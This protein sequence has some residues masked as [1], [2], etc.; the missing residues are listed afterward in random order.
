MQFNYGTIVAEAMNM[1][2]SLQFITKLDSH[3]SFAMNNFTYSTVKIYVPRQHTI[4]NRDI[5]HLKDIFV[6]VLRHFKDVHVRFWT[7][8]CLDC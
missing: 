6:T 8:D 5:K 3:D 4:Q 2:R 1:I 7:L